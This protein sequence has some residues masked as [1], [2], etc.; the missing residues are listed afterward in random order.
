MSGGSS[1]PAASAESGQAWAAPAQRE[2]AVKRR[3]GEGGEGEAGEEAGEGA[4]AVSAAMI[5]WTI[6]ST[7]RRTEYMYN[8]NSIIQL[9]LYIE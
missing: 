2:V 9:V 4:A 1:A 7:R 3:E 5:D 6:L 8:S